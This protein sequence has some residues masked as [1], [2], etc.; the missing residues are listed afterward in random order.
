MLIFRLQ[1]QHKWHFVDPADHN[2]SLCR[3]NYNAN[4]KVV[5]QT[6]FDGSQKMCNICVSRGYKRGYLGLKPL[7]KFDR[8]TVHRFE[9]INDEP[10]KRLYKP[11]KNWH[12][13][14]DPSRTNEITDQPGSLT[15][16]F[17][18]FLMEC[19]K[20]K[21]TGF[22]MLDELNQELMS[23]TKHT[24]KEKRY[25]QTNFLSN[26]SIIDATYLFERYY[27]RTEN[28][29]KL[30]NSGRV[31]L[32]NKNE[33]DSIIG[34]QVSSLFLIHW[35]DLAKTGKH[36]EMNQNWLNNSKPS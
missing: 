20:G 27:A 2:H 12:E 19:L 9:S 8:K 22:W 30:L 25:W 21:Q 35:E 1:H 31:V 29:K 5:E 32:I 6:E 17:I 13:T 24:K 16:R 23:K 10:I 15:N 3:E 33:K 14:L 18:G 28:G 26:D 7:V 4:P 11:E 36:G 34:Y